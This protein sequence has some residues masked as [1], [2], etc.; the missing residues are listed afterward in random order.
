MRDGDIE[1]CPAAGRTGNLHT[2]AEYFD[3][4]SEPDKS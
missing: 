3:A 1:R 4:V 2:T